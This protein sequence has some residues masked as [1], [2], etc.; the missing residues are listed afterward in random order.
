MSCLPNLK[1]RLRRNMLSSQPLC[2]N[3][4][5]PL[6]KDINLAADVFVC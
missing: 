1:K 2:F 3:L 5:V 4:F 6:A